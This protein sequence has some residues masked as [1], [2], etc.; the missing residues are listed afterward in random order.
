MTENFKS[1]EKLRQQVQ[2]AVKQAMIDTK[3]SNEG[4]SFGQAVVTHH[5]LNS[6]VS[7]AKWQ[8][9]QH[10]PHL[11]REGA[12]SRSPQKEVIS[13]MSSMQHPST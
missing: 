7:A 5:Y 9:V 2:G 13:Q 10:Q 4:I 11:A 3:Y 8:T 12:R 1:N 6:A